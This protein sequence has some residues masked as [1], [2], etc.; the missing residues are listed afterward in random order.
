MCTVPQG[1]C[2]GSCVP[3]G[4]TEPPGRGVLSGGQTEPPG[5]GVLTGGQTD[6]P[7]TAWCVSCQ[8]H[9][10]QADTG[11]QVSPLS[12]YYP[13]ILFPGGHCCA[14][15][16]D[17]TGHRAHLPTGYIQHTQLTLLPRSLTASMTHC[18]FTCPVI[19]PPAPGAESRGGDSYMASLTVQTAPE[20]K[21]FWCLF[22]GSEHGMGAN[23]PK[24]PINPRH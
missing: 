24:Q 23:T 22:Q 3:G 8:V 21:W 2:H 13:G 15:Q 12:L 5:R 14:L 6:P 4:E 16:A 11:G 1:P 10:I 18:R 17:G 19:S 9:G 7:G 20:Q